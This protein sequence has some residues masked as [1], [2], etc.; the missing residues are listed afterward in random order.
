MPIF[1]PQVAALK[2]ALISL[3]EGRSGSAPVGADGAAGPDHGLAI[4]RGRELAARV[5]E[6]S[7]ALEVG[8]FVGG[9]RKGRG[10]GVFTFLSHLTFYTPLPLDRWPRFPRG[11]GAL[12]Y[13]I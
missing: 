1:P 3:S 13:G 10:G 6:L 5:S 11:G 4:T 2:G 9:R 7:A 12:L 8:I